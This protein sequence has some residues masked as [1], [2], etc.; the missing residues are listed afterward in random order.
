LPLATIGDNL[1]DKFGENL[2]D[3]FF[4]DV[5]IYSGTNP[6]MRT[7]VSFSP[8]ELTHSHTQGIRFDPAVS[9][10]LRLEF[11][12]TNSRVSPRQP[13]TGSSTSSPGYY[14]TFSPAKNGTCEHV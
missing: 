8:P 5:I 4:P 7:H 14:N 13:Q 3:K 11:A 12:R 1:T 6:L 10:T 2:T 9:Q